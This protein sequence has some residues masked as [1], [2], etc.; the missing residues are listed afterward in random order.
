MITFRRGNIF[1]SGA[2][3]LVNTVNCKGVM[4]AGVALQ[5]KGRWPSM[6]ADYRRACQRGEVRPGR[7]HV[8]TSVTGD[9]TVINFPTKTDWRRDSEYEYIESGLA[10]LRAY[11]E[12][13]PGIRIAIPP[14]GCGNGKL[15]WARVRPMIA[16]ALGD[17]D[18]HVSVF[19]PRSPDG[20]ALQF[21]PVTR[22][23]EVADDLTDRIVV[24]TGHRPFP[25]LGGYSRAAV[26]RRRRTAREWIAALRPRGVIDGL[27][28]GF[29]LDVFEECVIAKVPVLACQPCLRQERIWPA[30]VQ[31]R[32]HELLALAAKVEL[33]TNAEYTR[34]CMQ[35]RNIYMVDR[36]VNHPL[37]RSLLLALWDGTS[38]GT[39]NCLDYARTTGIEMINAWSHFTSLPAA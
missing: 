19:E 13:R 33:V 12:S 22:P 32:Y 38:G 23:S 34:D 37:G 10:A 15:E 25:K 9:V 4:G 1:E 6:F 26:A 5:A 31:R 36:A 7:L 27:A 30:D 20:V 2:P 16:E 8:W 3:V 18:A 28:Q 29:D 17:L 14:L 24:I 35:R 21:L 11:I 39:Y